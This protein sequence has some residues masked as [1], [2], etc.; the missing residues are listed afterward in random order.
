MGKPRSERGTNFLQPTFASLEHNNSPPVWGGQNGEGGIKEQ[1]V[2]WDNPPHRKRSP[3]P[4]AGNRNVTESEKRKGKHFE[5][6]VCGFCN[7][8]FRVLDG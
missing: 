3:P 7:I 5:K 8:D 4:Q 1:R 6:I 2:V